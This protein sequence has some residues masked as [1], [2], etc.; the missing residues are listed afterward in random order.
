MGLVKKSNN[1]EAFRD[2]C[3]WKTIITPRSEGSMEK[4]MLLEPWNE[5]EREASQQELE[6]QRDRTMPECQKCGT[7][8]WRKQGKK[9]LNLSLSGTFQPPM[10]F[11]IVTA[12]PGVSWQGGLNDAVHRA[13]WDT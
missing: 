5:A 2:S 7:N 4:T 12:H 11:S 10:N 9:Y 1:V 8:E 13:P 6:S 3:Q